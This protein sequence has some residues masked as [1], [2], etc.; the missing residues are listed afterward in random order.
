MMLFRG[1]VGEASWMGRMAPPLRTREVSA[2]T[3]RS[4]LPPTCAFC[5][6]AD[7]EEES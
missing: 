6:I 3:C 5:I 4:Q 1:V 7:A 2:V